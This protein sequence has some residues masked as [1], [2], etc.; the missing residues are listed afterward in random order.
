MQF[1]QP[2]VDLSQGLVVLLAEDGGDVVLQNGKEGIFPAQRII[3]GG[4]Q[5]LFDGAFRYRAG[6]AEQAGVFQPADAAPDNRFLPM[7]VPVDSAENLAA[8][9]ADIHLREA[10]VAS[11]AAFFPILTGMNATT[12]DQLFLHLHKNLFHAG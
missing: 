11:E 7:V 3:D 12:S 9:T 2:S 6:I 10:V 5:Y 1:L 8:V 4:D